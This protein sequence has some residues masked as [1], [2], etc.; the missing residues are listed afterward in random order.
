MLKLEI[1]SVKFQNAINKVFPN[2]KK[3][4][5]S[6]AIVTAAGSGARMGGVS[7]QLLDLC[8]KPC[9]LYSLLAF[10][11][12]SDISE[13]I[14]VARESEKDLIRSICEE[15]GITKLK[16]IVSGGNTRQASVSNGFF[17]ISKKSDFVLIHDAARPLILPESITKLLKEAHRFGA[18]TAAKKVSDTIKRSLDGDFISETVPRDDLFAVQTPQVFKTDLYRVSLALA[19]KDKIEVTDDCSLAEHAG[20]PVKLCDLGI[21]NMKLTTS[22][23]LNLVKS[24][25][26]ERNHG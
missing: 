20:F 25:L 3:E 8:G 15:H 22:D 18:A 16:A 14:V 10:Q 12:C 2:P 5:F 19:E 26:M 23:D 6:S 24:I 21:Q 9:L 17:A 1:A 13:I 4:Y 11:Q 7:K